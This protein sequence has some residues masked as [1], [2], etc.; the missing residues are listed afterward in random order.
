MKQV[1]MLFAIMSGKRRQD[2][3]AVLRSVLRIVPVASVVKVVADFEASMWQSLREVL[4]NIDMTGCLFHYTQAIFRKVQEVGLQ[5]AYMEEPNTRLFVRQL[6]A[7]PVLPVEHVPA[8]FRR[9]EQVA[10]NSPLM[11]AMTTYMRNYWINGDVFTPMDCS[12]FRQQIRTNNEGLA[13]I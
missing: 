12:V 2:Y 6:M 11:L 5:R 7:L 13:K 3:T 9:L 8:V 4:P 10:G 1:P